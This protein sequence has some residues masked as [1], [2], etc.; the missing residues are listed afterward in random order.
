M[1]VIGIIVLSLISSLLGNS[2]MYIENGGGIEFQPEHYETVEYTE[3]E[4]ATP[5]ASFEVTP[6]ETTV[7]ITDPIYGDT[8]VNRATFETVWTQMGSRAVVVY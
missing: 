7:T 3:P 5:V 6:M 1:S 8:V 2:T 4:T